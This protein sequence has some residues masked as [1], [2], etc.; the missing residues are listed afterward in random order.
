VGGPLD[1][2]RVIDAGV[3]VQAPQAAA[4]LGDMG[5]DVIKVELPGLGDQA[6]WLPVSFTDRRSAFF[7]ACNRG[8]RSMTLDLRVAA[9]K[10]VFLRLVERADV[11][12]TNFKPGTL[13]SWDLGYEG[14]AKVNPRLVFAAG[15]AF[16]PLGPDAKREGADLSGQASGGLISATGT[17][18]GDPTPIAVTV[19]D[20]IGAQNLVAGILAALVARASTGV[21]Q[22]VDVSLLGS[23]IWAQASEY[24]HFL[25]SGELP[26]RPNRGHP[27]IPGLYGIFPTADGWIAIVGV[28]GPARPAFYNAIGRPDLLDDERFAGPLLNPEQKAALF[29]IVSDVLAQRST[30]AWCDVLE[31]AGQR[32]APVRTYA[33]VTKDPQ[34]WVNG[35]LASVDQPNGGTATVVGTPIGFSATP[36][37]PGAVAP[38]LGQHTEEILLELGCSWD[39]VTQLRD[40]GAI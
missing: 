32:Y 17:D 11:L 16:G 25:L 3:L 14:L 1:G 7:I 40:A 33:D 10:N 35:Y 2:L 24:T 21:G 4:L 28:V 15:S 6:R 19:C 39:D 13:E 12:V 36:A 26:G 23:Q 31:A 38:E 34:A 5:A 27:M 9:G 18:G 30:S 8:K 22:R 37:R 20:H 29:A